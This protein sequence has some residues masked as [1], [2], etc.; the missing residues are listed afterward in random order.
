MLR[1]TAHRWCAAAAAST[2]S[3]GSSSSSADCDG[4]QKRGAQQ[5]K[6]TSHLYR[7]AQL[8]RF[9]PIFGNRDEQYGVIPIFDAYCEYF[10]HIRFRNGWAKPAFSKAFVTPSFRDAAECVF[11]I[12]KFLD[13]MNAKSRKGE[14]PSVLRMLDGNAQTFLHSPE[15]TKKLSLGRWPFAAAVVHETMKDSKGYVEGLDEPTVEILAEKYRTQIPRYENRRDGG[16]QQH[17]RSSGRS[18]SSSPFSSE[19]SGNSNSNN[20]NTSTGTHTGTNNNKKSRTS[21][22][23]LSASVTLDRAQPKR[24]LQVHNSYYADDTMNSPRK[25]YFSGSDYSGKLPPS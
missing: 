18:V 13:E 3:H 8:H 11:L 6:S 15:A 22:A 16:R 20:F 24:R 17:S 21:L 5:G 7:A 10:N 12:R 9:D 1:R 25:P 2:S 19:W 14:G 23:S 4:S